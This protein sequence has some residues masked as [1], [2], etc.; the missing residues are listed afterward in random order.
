ML[1]QPL[2]VLALEPD[3]V[4]YPQQSKIWQQIKAPQ[5]WDLATGNRQIVV[6]VID[7][8]VDTWH[9]DLYEN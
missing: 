3:D 5:A 2:V 9:P 6:A 8:G 4:F 7:I 1:F